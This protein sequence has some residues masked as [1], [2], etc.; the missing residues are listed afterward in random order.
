MW[1]FQTDPEVQAQL[2][3]MLDFVKREVEPLDYR[4]PGH[5][6]PL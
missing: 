1:S 6:A 2:D 5:G 4:F 3:W